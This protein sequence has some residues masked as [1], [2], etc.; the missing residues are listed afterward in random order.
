[1]SDADASLTRALSVV[2]VL[3]NRIFEGQISPGAHLKEV[4][5]AKEL[6]LSRTPV[7]DA[8][9][10]L[11]EE[12]LLVYQPNRGFLVRRFEVKDVL[13]ALTL[14]ASLEGLACR[15]IGEQGLTAAGKEMLSGILEEQRSIVHGEE[16]SDARA[17]LWHDLNL[18][19]HYALLEL[20][21]NSWLTDAVRRARQLPLIFD[22]RSRPHDRE[23]IFLMYQRPDIQQAYDE[24]VRIVE[25][26]ARRENN[27]AE[28]LMQEHVLTN[29]DVLV[30]ALKANA[31]NLE[32]RGHAVS[33]NSSNSGSV[34]PK[35]AMA[36]R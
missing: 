29:R 26:L 30:R 2:D 3:R 6:G 25:L 16:W 18:D 21:D 27:R 5:L 33:R 24:H 23:A 19:F 28:N 31:K 11:A 20:A 36:E 35:T 4:V 17:L 8:L 12:G 14:R 1:M 9:A 13:D 10:R 34:V 7:R 15:L 22:S 32:E